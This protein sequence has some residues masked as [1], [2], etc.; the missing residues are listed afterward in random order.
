MQTQIRIKRN[1]GT[2]RLDR[3]Q[4]GQHHLR[5]DEEQD[6]VQGTGYKNVDRNPVVILPPV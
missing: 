6:R 2:N 4:A 3:C 1:I 5:R